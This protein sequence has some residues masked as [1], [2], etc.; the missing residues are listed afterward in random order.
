MKALTQLLAIMMLLFSVTTA[1]AEKGAFTT[2]IEV[3]VPVGTN[4]LAFVPNANRSNFQDGRKAIGIALLS[5]GEPLP[6]ES[7]YVIQKV[8]LQ[9]PKG[10]LTGVLCTGQKPGEGHHA[11]FSRERIAEWRSG[12]KKKGLVGLVSTDERAR[13]G[14]KIPSIERQRGYPK[15]I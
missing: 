9:I 6:G 5:T 15:H 1:S 11:Y 4:A 8:T 7:G 13:L 14:P 10:T 12:E 3:V 2:T